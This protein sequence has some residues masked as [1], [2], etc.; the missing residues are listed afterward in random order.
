[1]QKE[2]IANLLDFYFDPE[3]EDIEE[4][5]EELKAAGVDAEKSGEI[6]LG[7]LRDKKRELKLEKGRRFKEAFSKI[8][9]GMI[10]FP[11][12]YQ[13]EDP[14]VEFAFSKLKDAGDVDK[15]DLLTDEEKLKILEFLKNTDFD[16]ESGE[17]K[18]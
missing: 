17:S 3:E 7:M 8:V 15:S 10:P 5:Q 11:T 9:N 4:T 2:E 12:D 16:A 6:I 14:E 18:G 13:F 1:M